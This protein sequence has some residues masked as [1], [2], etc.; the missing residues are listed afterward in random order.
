MQKLDITRRSRGFHVMHGGRSL[1]GPFA[2]RFEAEVAVDGF[3]RNG[4][5][6][7]RSC[8]QC[9][10]RFQSQGAHNRMCVVCRGVASDV[11]DG[12]V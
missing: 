1:A 4:L 9:G 10:D 6:R 5:P 3:E 2:E 8:I 7:Q 12:A 11:F